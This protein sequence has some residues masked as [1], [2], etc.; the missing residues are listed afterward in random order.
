MAD[1]KQ[2]IIDQET[3]ASRVA[4]LLALSRAL[5]DAS[6]NL[7]IL[8]EGNTSVAVDEAHL[9]VKASGS[10]LE[11]LREE[12][13]TLCRR[14]PL[15]N[16]LEDRALTDEQLKALLDSVKVNPSSKK[17]SIE[18]IFH[19]WLLCLPGV[20]YVGHTHS[21]EANKILCSSTEVSIYSHI[22]KFRIACCQSGKTHLLIELLLLIVKHS[23]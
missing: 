8:G 23:L 18:T 14:A 17:P 9:A 22:H 1:L 16:A 10:V 4:E 7:C 5:G 3:Q 2:S 21:L 13:V 20:N 12:D 19:A 6:R 11:R 15:L